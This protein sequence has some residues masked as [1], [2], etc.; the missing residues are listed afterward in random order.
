M[1]RR[2][3]RR[4]ELAG[5]RAGGVTVSRQDEIVLQFDYGQIAEGRRGFVQEMAAGVKGRLGNMARGALE[6][7]AMLNAIR[8]DFPH[9]TWQ[10]FLMQEYG[11]TSPRQPQRWMQAAARLG[12]RLEEFVGL[13]DTVLGLLA[14]ATDEVIV[15]VA[16]F[17]ATGR[18]VGVAE[19]RLLMGDAAE[20]RDPPINSGAD[21]ENR[22]A[23]TTGSVDEIA[24]ANVDEVGEKWEE[25][26]DEK[27]NVDDEVTADTD[28]ADAD[29]V[30]VE[31][32]PENGQ[33]VMFVD[34]PTPDWEALGW[35]FVQN[36]AGWH[37]IHLAQGVATDTCG[38]RNEV[39]HKL[40]V[41]AFS[42]AFLVAQRDGGSTGSP[43][44]VTGWR[45]GEVAACIAAER[46][47]AVMLPEWV[48]VKLQVA[49][50]MGGLDEVLTRP[51][52]QVLL[53]ALDQ[54]GT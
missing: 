18:T 53:G 10:P 49:A 42:A 38:T 37:A 32:E 13:P 20:K 9:G 31:A 46:R 3:R 14:G 17:V 16:E 12:H 35:W 54:I 30:V 39:V 15:Q 50:E 23:G 21:G 1:G 44:W 41:G 28:G 24:G 43:T 6:V 47:Y 22:G 19:V 52:V 11:F 27:Q 2:E 34:E 45:S 8:A 29:A 5:Q 40:Q 25:V 48:L 36:E 4:V 7:G 26:N 33:L 51:G